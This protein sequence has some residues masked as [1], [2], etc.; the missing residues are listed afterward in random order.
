MNYKYT[1]NYKRF[2]PINSNT[3]CLHAFDKKNKKQKCHYDSK[4]RGYS[5]F[6]AYYWLKVSFYLRNLFKRR[7]LVLFIHAIIHVSASAFIS[8]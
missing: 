7:M 3:S 8:V 1:H 6:L 2:L 5:P 4:V